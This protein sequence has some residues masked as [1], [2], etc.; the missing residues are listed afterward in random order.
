MYIPSKPFTMRPMWHRAVSRIC[1][2]VLERLVVELAR[3][4]HHLAN[5]TAHFNLSYTYCWQSTFALDLISTSDTFVS[6]F[7]SLNSTLSNVNQLEPR[8]LVAF[9]QNVYLGLISKPLLATTCI[10]SI[11]DSDLKAT[12]C[13]RH[14]VVT[15]ILRRV[16]RDSRPEAVISYYSWFLRPTSEG[17]RT[18]ADGKSSPD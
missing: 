8:V 2:L 10:D 4:L 11:I 16:P 13:A 5:L 18:Y 14:R 3:G 9:A 6:C 7:P 12:D 1:Q 17:W 15:R